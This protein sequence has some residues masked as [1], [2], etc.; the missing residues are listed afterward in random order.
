MLF[1]IFKPS[2][3]AT[4]LRASLLL[5]S[6]SIASGAQASL[7]T[8][9][10]SVTDIASSSLFTSS[11]QFSLQRTDAVPG[12]YR[13]VFNDGLGSHTPDTGYTRGWLE[14]NWH[15]SEADALQR[16]EGLHGRVDDHAACGYQCGEHQHIEVAAVPLPAA[17]WMFMP[18][19]MAFGAM[20][21]RRKPAEA[22]QAMSLA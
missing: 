16:N 1:S 4:V 9:A 17:L 20:A 11:S 8:Y 3:L 19:L 14:R 13:Q 5:T 2:A 6:L 22:S 7:V 21:R 12:Q 10:S 18:A 15:E